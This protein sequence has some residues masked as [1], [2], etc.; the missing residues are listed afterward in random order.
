MGDGSTINIWS[1]PWIPNLANLIPSPPVVPS[2]IGMV[3]DLIIPSQR[4]WN[5]PL[6]RQFFD[7]ALVNHVLAIPLPEGHEDDSWVWSHTNDHN[8]SVSSCYKVALGTTPDIISSLMGPH[9]SIWVRIWDLETP[10]KVK[11]FA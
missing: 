1:D 7:E 4:V 9:S 6:L 2:D 5:E 8:F 3:R 11:F 10:N